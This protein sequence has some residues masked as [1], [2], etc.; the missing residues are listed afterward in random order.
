MNKRIT[1]A[2]TGASGVLYSIRLLRYLMSK[3]F[4]VDLIISDAGKITCK[5]ELGFDPE[6]ESMTEF[7]ASKFGASV[8]RGKIREFDNASIAA[9]M[10]SGS[11]RRLA[12]VVIPCSMKTLSALANGS[13][14]NL[15][16]RSADV[17]LKENYPL[18]VVPRETPMNTIQIENML[19]LAKVGAKIVPAMPAFYQQPATLDDLADFIAGRVL[20]LL[21]IDD[22]GLFNNWGN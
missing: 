14:S 9:P 21:G 7:L 17:A 10:A 15:I 18:I 16:E 13:S 1:I 22:H 19:K 6:K 11:V 12:M 3:E 4:D 2:I 20:N 5:L 8:I